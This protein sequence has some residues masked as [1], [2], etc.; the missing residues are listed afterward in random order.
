MKQ[1]LCE[2]CKSCFEQLFALF[3]NKSTM[4]CILAI[5]CGKEI[6][7]NKLFELVTH[8]TQAKPPP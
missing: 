4:A 1:I 5:G 3:C 6:D 7:V 8:L 2:G